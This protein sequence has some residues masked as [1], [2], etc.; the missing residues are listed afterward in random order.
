MIALFIILSVIVSFFT[1]TTAIFP[2]RSD[3]TMI[4]KSTRGESGRYTFAEALLTGIAPDGGLFVPESFPLFDTDKLNKMCKMDYCSLAT[5]IFSEFATDFTKGEITGCIEKAYAGASFPN[6]PAPLAQLSST[7]SVLELWHGPTSAFKDMALQLLPQFM[8]AALKKSSNHKSIAI[9]T[10][11]SGDTG[12]AALEGFKDADNIKILVFYPAEGVS[13][14]QKTQMVTQEGDNLSVIA[15]K[16]N[17]DDAQTGVKKLFADRELAAELEKRGYTLSSANSINIGRLLPQIVYYFHAYFTLVKKGSID[18]GTKINFVVPTGNFGNI[19]ACY[20]A[21][22]MGLPINKIICATND[23][24]VV[25][26]FM[27]TGV[28]NS[29]RKFIL[30]VSPAMD[31]LISSNLERL[32]YDISDCDA[33][34]VNADME[35][36]KANGVYSVD[37]DTVNNINDMF[38]ASYADQDECKATIKNVYDEFGYLIDPH[39]AVGI[40]VY[41]KYVISTGDT[42]YAVAVSTA[43]P[44]KFNKTVCEA[45]FG[46]ESVESMSEFRILT[47]LSDR[48]GTEIPVPLRD[49]D[50]K[51]VLHNSVCDK[52]GMKAA[53]D[54]FIK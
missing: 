22:K 42:S 34:A 49:L 35:D 19:L 28:Y 48:T 40:D 24:N 54:A 53:A 20:Y 17:F 37:K 13:E 44:F 2:F 25:S 7:L 21:Y 31:I 52:D 38:W 27:T 47:E 18:M 16:G 51:Q 8:S 4:Y 15:V 30:T 36:L 6:D 10:A 39:T 41:D 50:K 1:R 33:A 45:I 14:M 46:A 12:K 29:K 11:T 9:L 26:D 5:E 43:S 3:F 32:I 23:N